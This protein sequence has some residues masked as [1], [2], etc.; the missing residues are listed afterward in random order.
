[1]KAAWW[2]ETWRG[3]K[4]HID[5]ADGGV[6]LSCILTSASL[7]DSQAATPLATLTGGRVEPLH[8]LMDSAYDAKAI[9]A[10]CKASGQVSIIKPNPRRN[11]ALKAELALEA[12][13]QRHAGQV[14]P[15]PR[16]YRIRS[17]VERV[18]GRLKDEFGGR[19]IFVRGH[20]RVFAHLMFGIVALTVDQLRRMRPLC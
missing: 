19:S 12:K 1:M 10:H 7:H 2:G 6:P 15:A 13:A 4:L 18:N 11:M 8:E 17:T 3:C 5:S 14:D 9:K 16:R 20:A